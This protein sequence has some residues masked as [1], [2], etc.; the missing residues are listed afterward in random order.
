M[1][2]KEVVPHK[3]GKT[4]GM[5]NYK[6]TAKVDLLKLYLATGNLAASAAAMKVP[7]ATA[8]NWKAS[9]WWKQLEAEL[10][11]QEDLQLSSK[12]KNIAEKSLAVLVD[13]LD[14]GDF[15]YDPKTKSLVRI[16]VSLKDAN[17]VANDMID[18][19]QVLDNKRVETPE[20]QQTIHQK[21][22]TIAARFQELAA[23]VQ[24]KPVIEVTDVIEV[25]KKDAMV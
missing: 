6:D 23:K 24:A 4:T 8:R 3:R 1:T 25:E 9:D 5:H 20:E 16:P 12:L 10:R 2:E 13:R 18:R 15:R 22:D 7:E 19:S 11:A 17:K 21:L 14:Q